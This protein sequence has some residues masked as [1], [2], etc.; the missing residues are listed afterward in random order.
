MKS[1][2]RTNANC[3]IKVCMI[4]EPDLA[5]TSA[6]SYRLFEGFNDLANKP[7]IIFYSNLKEKVPENV[8]VKCI[9]TS[10]FFPFQIL[11]FCFIDKPDIIHIQYAFDTF[12]DFL[13]NL[14]FPL[15]LVL[16]R[17][18]SYKVVINIHA[19]IPLSVMD[20]NFVDRFLNVSGPPLVLVILIK[21]A[22]VFIY[23]II[24]IT[25]TAVV[26]WGDYFKDVLRVYYKFR[27]EKIYVIP[28]GVHNVED[29]AE[30]S[31]N[32]QLSTILGNARILLHFGGVTPRKDLE[33]LIKAF[34]VISK[35]HSDYKLVMAGYIGKNY[36]NYA[37]RLFEMVKCLGLKENVILRGFVKEE[38]IHLLY[39]LAEIVV[40]PYLYAFEGPSGPYSFAIAYGKP[41]VAS[42]VGYITSEVCN[43]R[44]GVLYTV[45]DPQGLADACELLIAN[46]KLRSRIS[47][48]L[49]DKAKRRSWEQVAMATCKLYFSLT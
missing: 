13:D 35:R 40:L 30:I 38:E 41:V 15:L 16:L 48:N 36:E 28:H 2:T 22:M 25:S 34:S 17:I 20:R 49:K 5:N 44:D 31:R 37:R 21:C 27:A 18:F 19:T 11:R 32:Y 43:M 7:V 9:W 47:E 3:P 46:P 33:T 42:N 45:K 39:N 24:D 26:V 23:K 1:H 29:I 6:Y 12:G 10:R 14:L 8:P 4:N